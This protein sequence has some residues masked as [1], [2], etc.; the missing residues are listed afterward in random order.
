[1]SDSE[2]GP[3]L[4]SNLAHDFAQRFR[5]GE[6]PALSEYTER[7]PELAGEI[8][9]LFPAL[10][11]ME[12]FGSVAGQPPAS[13]GP[14]GAAVPRQLGEYRLLREIGRG[15]MGVVY[16]AVQESLGRHVALKVLPL[17]HLL[18]PSYRERFE[19]EARAAARLHHTN[20][21]PVFGVG[22]DAGVRYYAMQYIQGQ[23]LDSVLDEVRRLRR[24]ECTPARQ[25]L[26]TSIAQGLLSGGTAEL[27]VPGSSAADRGGGSSELTGPS[28]AQYF[29]GVARVGVQVA[30]A[31]AHAHRQGIV[32]RDVKPSN[33]LMD[34]QG[35]VWV[36]DFGLVKDEASTDLTG[37]GDI[38]GTIRYMAPERF[39]DQG[40]ARSDV[41]SLGI[42]LYEMLTLRPAF[43]G[44]RRAELIDRVRHA[45]PPR[46]RQLDPHIP[47]DLETV[48][49]KALAK[50]PARRYPTAAALAEDLRR[51]LADR[52]VLARRST[53]LE[54]AWRWCRRN[55][56]VAALAAGVVLLLAVLLAGALLSNARLQEQLA[57]ADRA[58][59]GET[60]KRWDSYLASAQ[61]SR[62]SDRAGRRFEGLDAVRQAA[63][64]RPDLRLRNEAIALL[65]LADVRLAREIA[66]GYPPGSTALTFDPDFEHY[67]RSDLQGNIS[68][69]RVAGDREVQFLRGP[70]MAAHHLKFSPEGRFLAA[71]Y[72]N[73]RAGAVWDWRRRRLVLEEASDDFS[74][75]GSRLAVVRRDGWLSL[76]ELPSGGLV[77]RLLIGPPSQGEY[78]HW[79]HP[80]GKLLAVVTSEPPLLRIVDLDT[81][82]VIR[83]QP[84]PRA[85]PVAWQAGDTR[86][87]QIGGRRLTV[88]DTRSWRW[89]AEVSTFDTSEMQACFSPRDDLLASSA[90]DGRLRLWNPTTA[91]EQLALPGSSLPLQFSRDGGRLATTVQGASVQL[92]EVAGNQVC[93]VLRA[94]RYVKQ[95]TWAIHF[96]P[97]G[98]LLASAG[99]DGTRLWDLARGRDVADLPTGTCAGVVFAPDGLSL[100]TRT[101]AGLERWPIRTS[102]TGTEVGP[103]QQVAALK[104]TGLHGTLAAAGGQLAANLRERGALVLLDPQR[105]DKALTLAGHTGSTSAVTASPDG[106][107]VA[108]TGGEVP[109]E[110]RIS[111][112]RSGAIVW[113]YPVKSPAEFSP[114]S[115]RLV[116]GGDACRIWETGTWRLER[117]L[118]SSAGLGR[119]KHA[120]FA[121]DGITLAIAYEARVVRLVDARSGEELAT[122][123]GPELPAVDRLCF[124]PDGGL[125]ACIVEVMGVQLWD[126][127]RLRA[128]LADLGLDWEVPGYPPESTRRARISV[129]VHGN[130]DPPLLPTAPFDAEEARRLQQA[131]ASH[132]GVGVAITNQAGMKMR[133][134]PPGQYGPGCA[135]TAKPFYMGA[136]EVTVG[137]F[138][139]FVKETGYVTTDEKNGLGG[140]DDRKGRR[141]ELIW[142]HQDYAPS[143]NHPVTMVTWDDAM[144]FCTWLGR[145]EGR[146]YRLPTS[147]EWIW[148]ALAGSRGLFHFGA[149]EDGLDDHAWHR[150]NSGQRS[151]RVGEKKANPWGLFDLYGNVWELTYLWER[152]G[153]LVDQATAR[154]G[155]GSGDRVFLLGG[156]FW[157]AAP[158]AGNTPAWNPV[159]SVGY[160]H[161]GFRVVLVGDLQAPGKSR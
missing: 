119:V 158:T 71:F 2:S 159:P 160:F 134:I 105:P 37:P 81:G 9:E 84:W 148:A 62:W 54:R 11:M 77:K 99:A 76:F 12:A 118:E 133:L 137:Q 31:L 38:V 114:D 157:D 24:G 39:E 120:A 13:A 21:V 36:T 27:T 108:T 151:H 65:T 127:R 16:E 113:T 64:I 92:W 88:W 121:P 147:E 20:I 66:Q 47:R 143:D 156:S 78:R 146:T 56:L 110:L 116:T 128:R 72:N 15:G 17:H 129:R 97:D 152:G 7:Y 73:S 85:E 135:G 10:V 42:T 4:L 40:D 107:W 101:R 60:E 44:E 74:P 49:L 57:R 94:P 102:A 153:K 46:P 53:R 19:R 23:S 43:P 95:G 61:A 69:R 112:V 79:F 59:K 89:Q 111:D 154:Q 33:L 104:W 5:R 140:L 26:S 103:R 155:P 96:S 123:P 125:L 28:E 130:G 67:A 41:Y 50:E 142:S 22:E 117:T 30:E 141:R 131:W 87:V 68:I 138:R 122:L 91:R 109:D 45:E 6:R 136:C 86:L 8:R 115:R 29:V 63:A 3:D 132:L 144:A 106:R 75:D 34:T 70:P 14:P 83:T 161:F 124:S 18:S 1:M 90:S 98:T 48:V 58:E 52:P 32:H 149:A 93:R 25:P 139:Q 35:V 126:L 82:K 145:K 100:F 80:D 150:G 55:P 51:F